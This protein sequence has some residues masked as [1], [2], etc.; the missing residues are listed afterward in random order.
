MALHNEAYMKLLVGVFCRTAAFSF[1][2]P[3]LRPELGGEVVIIGDLSVYK[4][5]D[6][7][8]I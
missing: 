6:Y 7:V 4:R 2:T 3:V 8:L 5:A 1:L